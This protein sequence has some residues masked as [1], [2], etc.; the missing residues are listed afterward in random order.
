MV[1]FNSIFTAAVAEAPNDDPK[2]R[3]NKIFSAI[4]VNNDGE[5]SEEEFL[6]GCLKD[7]ELMKLLEKLFTVLASGF[8]G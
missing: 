2:V 4:D 6:K 8:E 7:D 5:L 1:K 3:A